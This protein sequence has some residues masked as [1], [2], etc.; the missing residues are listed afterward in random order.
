M[1]KQKIYILFI[2]GSLF[3]T[4]CISFE[5]DI[6]EVDIK[7]VQKLP[8]NL[9]E[10]S[11]MTYV[12]DTLWV[13]QDK[14]NSNEIH[15][16]SAEGKLLKSIKI[17]DVKNNDWEALTSDEDGNIYIGDFGNN[18]NNRK[19]LAIYKIDYKNLTKTEID[20]VTTTSF[21]YEDQ[22][23]FPP[24]KDALLFDCEAF[25]INNGD[26]YLFTKNRSKEFDGTSH[27]YKLHNEVGEQ[28]AILINKYVT[29]DEFNSCAITDVA[30]SPDKNKMVI[31]S[32]KRL[33]IF[34]DF[35]ES[36]FIKGDLKEVQFKLITKREAVTFKN[37]NIILISDEKTKKNGGNIYE[38]KL[39]E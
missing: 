32:Q 14:G 22:N 20:S 1:K 21:Y 3:C 12:N 16:I 26:F 27:I 13:I 11:G 19:N 18:L 33:W 38:Y 25:L 35:V 29:C 31:L 2:L 8:S 10:V 17:N 9:N 23:D 30:I 5:S 28:K 34:T 36:N 7:E 4:S 24:K 15:Q 37:N 39:E 6:K